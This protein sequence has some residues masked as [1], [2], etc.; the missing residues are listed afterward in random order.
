MP[1]IQLKPDTLDAE[2]E[3]FNPAPLPRPLFMTSLQK[4]GTHLLRNI[5]RMFVPIGQQYRG[6]VIQAQN[7][8]NHVGAFAADKRLFSFGHL[9][10]SPAA[11]AQLAP[12]P[13]LLLYRDPYDWLLA[14]ARFF[15]S[16]QFD[17]DMPFSKSED[18][19]A[20][21]LLSL[22]IVGRPG[23]FPPLAAAYQR[24]VVP[25]LRSRTIYP[26]RYEELVQ[27]SRDL[28][29]E[30]AELYFTNLFAATGIERPDNW[31]ERVS[32]GADPARSGTARENLSGI[33]VELPGE[34]P[35]RYRRLVDNSAPGLR[36]LLGYT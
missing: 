23:K 34:L 17:G 29:T 4:S 35:Q 20:D 19:G 31:R 24:F 22:M 27:N 14:R 25:W 36:K 5:L 13:K 28:V 1:R 6:G 7:L 11:A 21:E 16:D 10:F 9:R 26:L 30:E 32:V 12:V 33:R 3:R 8:Q 15:V 2:T 18:L